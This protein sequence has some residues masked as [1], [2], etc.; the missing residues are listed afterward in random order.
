MML[1]ISDQITN[2]SAPNANTVTTII[3]H[4]SQRT[5]PDMRPSRCAIHHLPRCDRPESR[6]R[7]VPF[8]AGASESSYGRSVMSSCH[9]AGPSEHVATSDTTTAGRS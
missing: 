5:S 4:Y 8:D 1:R 7:I 9:T 2:S 6:R 3:N